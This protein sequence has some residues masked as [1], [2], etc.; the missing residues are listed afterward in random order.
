MST[1]A[2]TI[3]THRKK[4]KMDS[5][6]ETQQSRSSQD[7]LTS[8]HMHTH[9]H[10]TCMC[11]HTEWRTVPFSRTFVVVICGIACDVSVWSLA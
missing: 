4:N 11:T 5:A 9:I 6:H 10:T 8:T 1:N 2:H 7:V 3:Y